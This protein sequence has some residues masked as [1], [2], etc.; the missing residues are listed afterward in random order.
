MIKRAG[1]SSWIALFLF[2]FDF[3]LFILFWFWINFF[4]LNLDAYL[5][6]DIRYEGDVIVPAVD[7]GLFFVAG[8]GGVLVEP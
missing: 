2:C 5:S 8:L 4:P 3:L 7:F 6:P 1:L